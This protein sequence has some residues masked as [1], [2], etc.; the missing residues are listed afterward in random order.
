MNRF[1]ALCATAAY[2]FLHAP[3]LVL[4]VFSFNASR[5]TQWEG[6]SWRWYGE[7]LKDRQIELGDNQR[8]FAVL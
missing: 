3:L 6:F 1:L 7:L 8:D 4:A 2:A 5:F